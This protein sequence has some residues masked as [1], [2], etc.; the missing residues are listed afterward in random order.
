[1]AS[2]ASLGISTGF[3]RA[4]MPL[5]RCVSFATVLLLLL[6]CS[7]AQ[8]ACNLAVALAPTVEQ[9][10][11]ALSD[12]LWL[13]SEHAI[14][15]TAALVP[16][17]EQMGVTR[18]EPE[19]ATSFS[20]PE[21]K[22]STTTLEEPTTTTTTEEPT[23]TTTT[24][25]PTTTTTTEE[26][27]T[28][29]TTEEPTTTTTT[30]EPTTTTTTEEPTTTTTTEEPTTTT[31]LPTRSPITFSVGALAGVVAGGIAVGIFFGVGVTLL[32][33]RCPC[34]LPCCKRGSQAEQEVD[35]N[36]AEAHEMA[37]TGCSG[38]SEW[39]SKHENGVKEIQN[40]VKLFNENGAFVAHDDNNVNP[41]APPF[42]PSAKSAPPLVAGDPA[43]V[44]TFN[45]RPYI[46][47]GIVPWTGR[48]PVLRGPQPACMVPTITKEGEVIPRE[49][50]VLPGLGLFETPIIPIALPAPS[51]PPPKTGA[52]AAVARAKALFRSKVLRQF[53]GSASAE[54]E[55]AAAEAA[56][57]DQPV[58]QWFHRLVYFTALANSP[59]ISGLDESDTDKSETQYADE[60]T[61]AV[62]V[63]VPT[64]TA[65]SGASDGAHAKP[66]LPATAGTPLLA[67]Y[68]ALATPGMPLTAMHYANSQYQVPPGLYGAQY[69]PSTHP[70]MPGNTSEMM[71]RG[72]LYDAD[73]LVV[74]AYG[75]GG[76]AVGHCPA[77]GGHGGIPAAAASGSGYSFLP[78]SQRSL[79][80]QVQPNQQGLS[81]VLQQTTLSKA[82]RSSVP[83]TG[84]H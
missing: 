24:E 39:S 33:M 46:Q 16:P 11:A 78:S 76:G 48:P 71:M 52:A 57:S 20:H 67:P 25:E 13:L 82:S 47:N 19:A 45:N 56:K 6:L 81:L 72:S 59:E 58:I 1:M 51:S 18:E 40:S 26:P 83:S 44:N 77:P 69:Y 84:P 62:V 14:S 75:M 41:L 37:E 15:K 74:P 23:T 73:H 31:A 63:A 50:R 38:S 43:H 2:M 7:R 60:D 17:V 80:P 3:T 66:P 36:F 49:R 65:A 27:T 55:Q 54:E 30:E 32:V 4:S 10:T 42:V 64:C 79:S 12:Q 29:T 5:I 9:S 22:M 8:Q 35:D 34:F 28:T 21:S 68:A 53:C 70:Q 61:A